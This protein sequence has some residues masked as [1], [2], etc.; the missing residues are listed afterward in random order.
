MATERLNRRWLSRLVESHQGTLLH[1]DEWPVMKDAMEY[2]TIC[3]DFQRFFAVKIAKMT[4]KIKCITNSGSLPPPVDLT[5]SM[6]ICINLSYHE[7]YHDKKAQHRSW[8]TSKCNVLQHLKWN[9]NTW[10]TAIALQ[11]QLSCRSSSPQ[12]GHHVVP[13]NQTSFNHCRHLANRLSNLA[14]TLLTRW[15]LLPCLAQPP[16]CPPS[17]NLLSDLCQTCKTH[18]RCHDAQFSEYTKYLY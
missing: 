13:T 18:V 10:D 12:P 17:W 7:I 4:E 16:F 5:S 1:S 6:P 3:N 8:H 11:K 9:I 15:I 2:Q 14:I